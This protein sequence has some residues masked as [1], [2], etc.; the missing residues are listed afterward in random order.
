MKDIFGYHE[1]V[2]RLRKFFQEKKK[3]IEVPA[4]S[5]LSIL[6]ACEDPKT[7]TRFV[8]DGV[9]YPLPQTG[10]MWLEYELLKR[11]DIVGVFCVTTSYRNEPDPVEGRH[12][13]IFPMF[14]FEAKGG[15]DALKSLEEE[16]L[17]FLGFD[18]PKSYRYEE[19][20]QL[21]NKD[22]LDAADELRMEKEFGPVISLE[23]FPE[24][25]DPFW[26][27]KRESKDIFNKID[28]ILYGMETVGSA[29]RA[30]D[31]EEMR[32]QF[33]RISDGKY[34]EL[35]FQK[36]GRCRVMKELDDY[37]DLKMFQ[38][39]GGGIGVTRLVRAM[40]L[41]GLISDVA[42]PAHATA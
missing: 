24:R 4:Q 9:D 32:E 28:V 1:V 30:T 31:V 20:C 33:L 7:I 22:D 17:L 21:W 3:F 2:T 23:E 34:A 14:E 27:M 38:R 18:Q 35:L 42:Y 37:L 5:R 41:A 16:M 26:N 8:F 6:A 15:M 36:F 19:I 25:T 11:P 40:R 29:E 10:Q 39:F 12:D 13:K